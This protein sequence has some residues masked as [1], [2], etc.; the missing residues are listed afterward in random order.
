MIDAQEVR[1][2]VI[3]DVP[4]AY[5]N[6]DMPEYEFIFLKIKGEFVDCICEVNPKYK[7]TLGV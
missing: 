5:L 3:F 7:N 2:V 6:T 4:G 1:G